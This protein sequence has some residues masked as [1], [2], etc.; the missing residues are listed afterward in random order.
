M[1]EKKIKEFL[2]K[3]KRRI[4]ANLFLHSFLL[5]LGAGLLLGTFIN[6]V[7]L[8]LPVYNAVSY[9]MMAAFLVAVIGVIVMVLRAPN[10]EKV[11]LIVDKTGLQEQLVTSL[12]LEGKEDTISMLQK[13]RT[14][15]SISNYSLKEHFPIRCSFANI[16][17]ATLAAMAFIIGAIMPSPAKEQAIAN[18]NLKELAKE[19]A[20]KIEE[21]KEELKKSDK[22]TKSDAQE[23]E[24]LLK[25]AMDELKKTED[26]SDLKKTKERLETKLEKK[27]SQDSSESAKE[28]E[29]MLEEKKLI[30]KTAQEKENEEIKEQVQ[31]ELAKLEKTLTDNEKN[32]KANGDNTSGTQ[33]GKKS[34]QTSGT[35]NQQ[36]QQN[37]S[38]QNMLSLTQQMNSAVQS[39]SISSQ[40]MQSLLQS[41][42]NANASTSSGNNGKQLQQLS[43]QMASML[44]NSSGN[45]A[46]ASNAATVSAAS[47]GQGQ[48]GMQ[49]QSG[50]SGNGSGNGSSSSSG[51]GNG[52]GGG[53][54]SGGGG[55]NYGS[56]KGME[57]ELELSNT[58]ENVAIPDGAIGTDSN[59]T[60]K[61]NGNNQYTQKSSD[62]LTWAGN[63]VNYNQVVGN[64]AAQAYSNLESSNIPS[65]MKDIVKAYFE[66]LTQ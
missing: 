31:Q 41:L 6:V 2:K 20:K 54:G 37:T 52:A 33:E 47:D 13:Q 14:C 57:R 12:E 21:V 39:N 32:G 43:N 51:N 19:E 24:K 63:S 22:V 38:N 49:G 8:I 46:M 16:M 30:Q 48:S 42:Q 61:K 1:E 15:K 4:W 27:L 59:L 26:K 18:H 10:N 35:E 60:G 65:S 50:Q 64:Y 44:A 62:S 45:Q 40:N 3:A 56:K 5:Y 66:G 58:E 25:E 11:A 9:A 36:G 29:K 53:N 34:E 55:Y 7:A 28:V 23:Y 17:L